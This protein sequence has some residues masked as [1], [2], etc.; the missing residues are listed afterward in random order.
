M[1][2]P[3]AISRVPVLWW[4]S[5]R[6]PRG[7]AP[8]D[9][10]DFDGVDNTPLGWAGPAAVPRPPAPSRATARDLDRGACFPDAEL[11][12]RLQRAAQ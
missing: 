11:R 1:A 10:D 5:Q 2:S 6:R 7:D 9:M 4:R 8:L 3:W 12:S